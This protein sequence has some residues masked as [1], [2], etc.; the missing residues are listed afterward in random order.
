MSCGT[1]IL[2]AMARF[3]VESLSFRCNLYWVAAILATY[4]LLFVFLTSVKEMESL[5]IT[6]AALKEDGSFNG[7]LAS[8]G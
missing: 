3:R 7:F 4:D 2:V 1:G 6:T 8:L 5:V